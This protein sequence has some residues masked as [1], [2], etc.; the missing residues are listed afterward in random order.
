MSAHWLFFHFLSSL[1]I[2]LCRRLIRLLV[3]EPLLIFYSLLI[4]FFSRM[5]VKKEGGIKSFS[6]FWSCPLD[7]DTP[8]VSWI[9][10]LSESILRSTNPVKINNYH[11]QNT[12]SFTYSR[13]IYVIRGSNVLDCIAYCIYGVIIAAQCTATFSRTIVLPWI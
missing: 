8:N 13:P 7:S 9:Q 10:L 5:L 12:G 1:P 2:Y 3:A 4:L 6:C 11:V